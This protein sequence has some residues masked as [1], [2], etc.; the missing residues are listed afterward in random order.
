[1][2]PAVTSQLK[3]TSHQFFF[4]TIYIALVPKQDKCLIFKS[5]YKEVWCVPSATHLP[6]SRQSQNKVL[7]STVSAILFHE[8][9]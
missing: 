7:G 5:D 2:K 8:T 1:M 4:T 9:P 6:C 3:N